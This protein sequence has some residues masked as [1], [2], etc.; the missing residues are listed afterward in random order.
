MLYIN[1]AMLAGLGI[2]WDE[3]AE[4][5][6]CTLRAMKSRDTAQPVKPYLR[7]R[8]PGNRIIAMPAYVGG[9]TPMAGIKWIA[10]FPGNNAKGL[11][12]THS[13]TILNEVDTGVPLCIFNTA[14]ISGIRT[15]AVSSVMLDAWLEQRS[16]LSKICVGISGFGPIGQLHLKMLSAM[17]KE[18]ELD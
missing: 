16:E 13:V 15:T 10:S 11:R 9:G 1:E 14:L 4:V 3:Q 18:R 12:R 5:I 6:R 17:A 8:D 2:K 7:Y